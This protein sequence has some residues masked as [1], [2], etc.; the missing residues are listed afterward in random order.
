MRHVILGAGPAGVTAAETLRKVDPTS[1]I[2]IV[3]GERE[4][5]YSRM[6]I[7]YLLEAKIGESGTYLRQDPEHYAKQRIALRQGRA[8]GI[9][10][11]RLLIATGATPNTPPIPG[12]DLEGVANCWTMEDARKILALADE[13]APV[14]L[15]GA[16]FIGS[17]V[18]EALYARGCKL[19][20]VEV[21]P[22]MV[23]RMMDDTAGGMLGDW[24]RAKGVTVLTDTKVMRIDETRPAD[25]AAPAAAPAPQAP[26]SN[27]VIGRIT[28][29]IMGRGPLARPAE[30]AP[31]APAGERMLNVTLSDG[32][33]IPAKLV[34]MAAGVKANVG[35]LKGS[36]VH[37]EAGIRVDHAM[38]TSVKDVYAAGDCAQGMDLSTGLHDVLAIQ[39]IAVEHGRIAALNM[40]GRPTEHRGSLNMNVL[41][42]MGLISCSFGLWQGAAGGQSV[43]S[44]D[45]DGWRYIRLEFDEDRLVGAQALGLID[46]VGALRGLIQTGVRLGKWKDTLIEAPERVTEA[47][48]ATGHGGVGHGWSGPRV[49]TP[50]V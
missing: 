25:R 13:G 40:A 49:K 39:P 26:Q 45:R 50:V 15:V 12:A 47:Y 36:G 14:V 9:P 33:V 10:F 3:S 8:V 11:A 21:A 27:G 2:T 29:Y 5:P 6:A 18:L 23:A 28:D 4:P 1:E 22:R 48:I 16:G 35:F 32:Q 31:A 46:H 19:T 43:K 24:C 37:V 30:P 17:I 34:V 20:V 38:H 44:V 42:T 7:P 41:D